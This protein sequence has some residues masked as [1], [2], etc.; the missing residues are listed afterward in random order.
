MTKI[1]TEQ[2]FLINEIQRFYK[3]NGRLP[4]I[5]DISIKNG[6]PDSNRYYNVFDEWNNV[7]IEAVLSIA[8]YGKLVLLKRKNIP[9]MKNIFNE[10]NKKEFNNILPKDT[11]VIFD[12]NYK[13]NTSAGSFQHSAFMNSC[14][15]II[16][17]YKTYREWGKDKMIEVLRHEMVHQYLYLKDKHNWNDDSDV[18]INECKKRNII[19]FFN[20]AK[21]P[22]DG[23]RAYQ[24]SLKN[25]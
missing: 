21:N 18:F 8:E 6:Y 1:Y 3:E 22:E 9:N 23:E 24:E 2:E 19:L 14:D 11:I 4:H 17:N 13:K 12:K 5:C 15:I 25:R 10:I 16:L 7:W 20:A